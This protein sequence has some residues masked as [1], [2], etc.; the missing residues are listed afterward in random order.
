MKSLILIFISLFTF[1]KV[2]PAQEIDW[3]K[4]KNWKVYYIVDREAMKVSTDSLKFMKGKSIHMDSIVSYLSS[5]SL[6]PSDKKAVW[7]GAYTLTYEFNSGQFRKLLA[8]SY[9]GFIYDS[10]SKQYYEIDE[11]KKNDW[12]DFLLSQLSRD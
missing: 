10:D 3:R 6:W 11:R 2:S 1:N 12:Q 5:A 7:M 4:T 8:S 9:G